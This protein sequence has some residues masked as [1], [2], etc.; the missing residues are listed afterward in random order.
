M[1]MVGST[2]KTAKAKQI[3]AIITLEMKE[4]GPGGVGLPIM[5]SRNCVLVTYSRI[6]IT[7]KMWKPRM[8]SIVNTTKLVGS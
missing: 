3:P 5:T 8:K 7:V 6:G 2:L 4:A 1:T